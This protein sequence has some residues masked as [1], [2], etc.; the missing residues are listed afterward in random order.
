MIGYKSALFFPLFYLLFM[1]IMAF[2]SD[3][4]LFGS[5]ES[6]E[7]SI[8]FIYVISFCFL[9]V[10]EF[11]DDGFLIASPVNPFIKVRKYKYQELTKI[12]IMQ[13][14]QTT[15]TIFRGDKKNTYTTDFSRREYMQFIDIVRHHVEV[16]LHDGHTKFDGYIDSATKQNS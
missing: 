11:Y 7:V 15:I 13:R 8:V 16:V 9:K 12:V 5:V 1:S 3:G 6:W 4:G 14:K 10:I 2:L